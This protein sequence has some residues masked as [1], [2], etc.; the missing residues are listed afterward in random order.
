MNSAN[1]EIPIIFIGPSMTRAEVGKHLKVKAELKP[2]VQRGDLENLSADVRIVCIIDGV[3]YTK[4]AVS[5][6]EVLKL[7]KRG[8]R[9]L[10]SSSMGALRAAELSVYGMEGIGEVFQ[11]YER[12]EID[13]DAEVA[14]T[15]NPET[16]EV[17]TEP[18]V[19][20]RYCLKRALQDQIL[21]KEE[22]ILVIG[23][24]KDIY[25]PGLTY[26]ALFARISRTKIILTERLDQLKN[27]VRN[28]GAELD[29]KR[30][31]ALALIN[32]LNAELG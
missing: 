17:V 20:I 7:L 8:V 16:Y 12:G 19:N 14:L 24:A 1:R 25:F 6:R 31:D 28:N 2:P 21:T 30:L 18:M 22:T 15:F 3:F 11:M 13:S 32:R 23:A 29:V 5:P 10:G 9:V 4:R 26:P 27:Y